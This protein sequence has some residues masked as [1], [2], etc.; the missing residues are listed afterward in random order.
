MSISYFD[1]PTMGV[2]A[3]VRR[4]RWV[5][6]ASVRPFDVLACV[7]ATLILLPMLPVLII[8]A[9]LVRLH[10]GGPVLFSQFRVGRHGRRFRCWKVRTMCVDSEARLRAHLAADPA[11][12]EEWAADQKLRVDP[13]VTPLGRFL[14][15]T[16][17]DELPQLYNVLVGDMSIVGPR[18]IVAEE[19][20]RYGRYITH[21]CAVRPGLTGVWQ[22]MGRNAVTYRR[23]VAM[24]VFWSRSQCVFFYLRIVALTV[25]AVVR[26]SGL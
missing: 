9:C 6:R 11:A 21:Y 1:L 10:D 7:A 18:P 17:L 24:D 15:Q 14:R 19:M 20:A 25:P 16:S 4:G 26:R 8:L 5:L 2:P 22:V 13:R 3:L 23:R 12:R